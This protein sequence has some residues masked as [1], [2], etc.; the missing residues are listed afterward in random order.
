LRQMRETWDSDVIETISL[1]DAGDRVV[2][3]Q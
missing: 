3:R 1:T 2:T